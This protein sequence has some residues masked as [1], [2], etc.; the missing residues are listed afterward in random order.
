M[1][2]RCFAAVPVSEAPAVAAKAWRV[3]SEEDQPL[4]QEDQEEEE[5]EEETAGGGG[6]GGGRRMLLSR[7]R[8][9]MI[10]ARRPPHCPIIHHRPPYTS[11]G[12]PKLAVV[13][14]GRPK[15]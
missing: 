7:R 8:W 6:G 3:R 10:T 14:A 11:R 12:R 4:S 9:R 2:R 1:F 15:F 5:E 13:D